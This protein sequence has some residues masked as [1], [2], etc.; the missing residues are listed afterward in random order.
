MFVVWTEIV[1]AKTDCFA[2]HR[3]THKE[4]IMDDDADLGTENTGLFFKWPPL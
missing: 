2:N 1:G 3:P 4:V